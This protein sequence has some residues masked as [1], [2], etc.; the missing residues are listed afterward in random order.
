MQRLFKGKTDNICLQLIRYF[1]VG[2]CAF[3]IDISLLFFLTEYVGIYYLIS[4]GI[5]FLV[6]L[7]V[8][9]FLSVSWVFNKRTVEN[10]LFEFTLFLVIGLIGLGLNELFLWIFTDKLFI[11]YLF[12]KI[13][14]TAIVCSW[15]FFARKFI[16]FNNKNEC[17]KQL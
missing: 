5:S 14:T 9:Y 7:T 6:A 2:G 11:Y 4:A 13:I 8:N 3:V 17:P 1:F 10:R 15:N 12:S 16:L